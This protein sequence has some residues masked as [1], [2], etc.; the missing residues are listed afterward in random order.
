MYK[1]VSLFSGVGG[2]DLAFEQAGFSTIFANDIDKPACKTFSRNFNVP[3]ICDDIKNIK[4]DNIPDCDCLVAGF[5]CQAFSIAGYRKGFEDTRGTLFFEI[6]RIIKKK[7]PQVVFLE[8]VKN[9]VAHDNGKTFEVILNTLQEIGYHVRYMVLNACEYGNIPQNRERI[10]IVGFLNEDYANKF[11]F[12]Q[13]IRLTNK[14]KDEIDFDNKV[15]DKYY[16]TREKYPRIVEEMN[17]FN[18]RDTLYQWRR[19]YVRQNKSNM[20]PTLTA[21]MGTG[22]HNVPLVITKYGIRKLTPKEC[23][24]L[25]GFPSSYELPNISTA[26]LYKQAGNS[27]CVTVIKRIAQAIYDILNMDNV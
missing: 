4:E 5:P 14:L 24:N 7:K 22:G 19:Q 10:Y 12:P 3:I 20:S 1:V 27:V 8:N 15:D 23:F 17:K 21:N 16:Y 2:I 25:Q 18:N 6:A 13:P 26:Q 9:L 11:Y